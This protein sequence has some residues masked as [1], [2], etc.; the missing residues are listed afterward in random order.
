M[1]TAIKY[2]FAVLLLLI[3]QTAAEAKNYVVCVGVSDYPG[4]MID[5]FVSHRDAELMTNLFRRN[6]DAEIRCITNHDATVKNVVRAMNETYQ[7][8]GSEDAVILFFSGHGLDGGFRC[9]DG[10]LRYTTVNNC[11]RQSRSAR[12]FVYADAC[13]SGGMRKNKRQIMEEEGGSILYFLSS[14]TKEPS[15]ELPKLQ[16]SA[17]T[18][19]LANGM[20]GMADTNGDRVVTARE[21]Y[22]YVSNNVMALTDRKQHPVMWG[23]FTDETAVITWNR[24]NED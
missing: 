12:R 3:S 18:H 19:Y 8:A 15:R 1:T 24:N 17:F 20:K 21:L 13:M 7:K 10:V 4:E 16:Q 9:Y 6:G 2:T 11:M 22:N 14:R 23:N 5:L